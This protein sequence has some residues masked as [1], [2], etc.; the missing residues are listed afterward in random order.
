M[1]VSPRITTFQT[2]E[3]RLL[4]NYLDSHIE[5]DYQRACDDPYDLLYEQLLVTCLSRQ[6]FSNRIAVH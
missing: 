1:F 6:R 2:T 3:C 4:Y 5:L